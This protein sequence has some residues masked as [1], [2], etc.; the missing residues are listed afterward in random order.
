M[1]EVVNNEQ[2]KLHKLV[3]LLNLKNF[4]T[5]EIV[6][7]SKQMGLSTVYVIKNCENA[8][9]AYNTMRTKQEE[10]IK[11]IMFKLQKRV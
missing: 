5:D 10:K 8:L 11:H 9:K 3:S 4:S 6:R 2:E 1:S 7:L